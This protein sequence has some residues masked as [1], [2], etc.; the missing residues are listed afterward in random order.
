MIVVVNGEERDVSDEDTIAG[1]LERLGVRPGAAGV[2]VA[3]NGEVV[4]RS[5]WS[6]VTLAA[7][8]RIEVLQAVQGG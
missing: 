5:R 2:A 4:L 7:G 1:V 8:D 3:R 6:D